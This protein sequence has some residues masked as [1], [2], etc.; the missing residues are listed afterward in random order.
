MSL[1][2]KRA[3]LRALAET[4]NQTLSAERAKVSRSW[5]SLHRST[6]AGFD[7]ACREA[8]ERAK[9]RFGSH[10]PPDPSLR[11]RGE[12]KRKPPA[13]W[14]FNAGEELVV[15]GTNGVRTQV[16]RAKL[17]QWTPRVEERFLS[18]LSA[19]CNVKA[20][21]AAVGMSASGAYAHRKRFPAFARAWDEAVRLG[22]SELEG[23]LIQNIDYAFD[24]EAA[25]PELEI[26]PITV[27]DL[28][29]T[30]RMY[31][32]RQREASRERKRW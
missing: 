18:A 31:D 16:R 5:V 27:S 3:F 6:D 24:P 22:M 21:L 2:R 9:G 17:K 23:A 11:G 10:P 29:R 20:A 14:Q 4:G 26:G 15:S 32:R 8:I 1:A 13:A 12:I 7:A 30:L 25:P 28:I 19:S